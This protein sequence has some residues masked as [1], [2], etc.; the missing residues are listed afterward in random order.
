MSS[1]SGNVVDLRSVLAVY[2]PE[3]TRYLF[4][5]TRPNTEFSI[6]FDLDVIKTY[7]DYD[8]TERIA[9]NKEPAKNEETYQKERR[10]WELSQVGEIPAIMPYQ[11]PFRH[12]CSL[13]QIADGDIDKTL[14]AID[15]L[16][17]EQVAGLKERCT[18]ALNWLAGY[19]PDEFCF[20]LRGAVEK[21]SLQEPELNA[22]RTLRE[23]VI[24]KLDSFTDDKTCSQ[25]VYDVATKCGIDPK[26]LFKASYQA[27]IAK[28]QGPRLASFLRTIGRERLLQILAAY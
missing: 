8:K 14:S 18:C 5:G 6:S 24:T 16:K 21:A 25:A 10:I 12:L 7:E 4:A 3:V 27:L 19:A 28:D 2:Q 15:G 9:F 1:S 22:V 20:K 23:D 11:V 17:P 13:L 26:A